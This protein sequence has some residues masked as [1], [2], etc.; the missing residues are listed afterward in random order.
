MEDLKNIKEIETKINS[1]YQK[2]SNDIREDYNQLRSLQK[3][4]F[5]LNQNIEYFENLLKN[6]EQSYAEKKAKSVNH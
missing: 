5:N 3:E 4:E 6:M 2:T 1:I